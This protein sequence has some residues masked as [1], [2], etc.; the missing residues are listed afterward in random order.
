MSAELG[1]LSCVTGL[2]SCQCDA[3]DLDLQFVEGY[4]TTAE[5]EKFSLGKPLVERVLW[6]IYSKITCG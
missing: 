3:I 1:H 4:A 5:Y 6:Q 2:R